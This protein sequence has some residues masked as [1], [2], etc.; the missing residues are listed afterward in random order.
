MR[1]RRTFRR[2]PVLAGACVAALALSAGLVFRHYETAD[3]ACGANP[4]MTVDADAATGGIE[5]NIIVAT[6]ANFDISIEA[7]AI[8][9]STVEG[10]QWEIGFDAADVNFVSATENS[11]V[12]GAVLCSPVADNTSGGAPAGTEWWGGG[13]GCLS[14]GTLAAGAVRLTTITLQCDPGAPA[15]SLSP[16]HLVTGGDG[17]SGEDPTFGTTFLGPGGT[18]VTTALTDATVQCGVGGALPTDTPTNTPTATATV[19]LVATNTPGPS[20]TPLPP[21]YTRTPTPTATSAPGSPTVPAAGETTPPGTGPTAPGG[22]TGGGGTGG[23]ITLPD[24]GT[25]QPSGGG[26]PTQLMAIAFA[27]ALVTGAGALKLSRDARRASR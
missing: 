5:T 25:G 4:C 8:P 9:A 12:H 21:D 6:G 16:L 7:S 15:G 10:Y 20:S 3:A 17:A 14:L 27:V 13:A 1:N 26:V 24:T 18:F 23:R 22:T 2:W 11:G 19:P